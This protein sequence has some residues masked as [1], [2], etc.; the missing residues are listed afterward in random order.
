[1][2]EIMELE[3]EFTRLDDE[4]NVKAEEESRTTVF[5]N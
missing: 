2:R 3:V 5:S 1:M 4:F